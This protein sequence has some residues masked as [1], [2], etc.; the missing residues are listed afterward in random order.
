MAGVAGGVSVGSVVVRFEGVTHPSS[1]SSILPI[2]SVKN[3]LR[4][5]DMSPRKF[6]HFFITADAASSPSRGVV[7]RLL[8]MRCG[9]RYAVSGS[10][11]TGRSGVFAMVAL[12]A[13]RRTLRSCFVR[14]MMVV[15]TGFRGRPAYRRM[16]MRIRG[17][18]SVFSTLGGPPHGGV[19]KL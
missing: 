13:P 19:R 4:G 1:S 10:S 12:E 6:P 5:L 9:L 15:L 2:I 11:N 3:V 17:L 14:V 18:V 8:S 16:T 7:E